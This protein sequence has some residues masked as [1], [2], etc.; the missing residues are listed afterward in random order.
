MPVSRST[1]DQTRQAAT[2]AL[3]AKIISPEV[4]AQL[5]DGTITPGEST[6]ASFLMARKAI[7]GGAAKKSAATELAKAIEAQMA[8]QG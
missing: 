5:T 4:F 8:E 1:L 6:K 2:R 7:F 3:E